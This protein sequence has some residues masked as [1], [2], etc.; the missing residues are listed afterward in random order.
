M[1]LSLATLLLLYGLPFALIV[2]W[3]VRS[4]AKRQAEHARQLEASLQAGL[5]E[6]ASLHPVVDPNNCLASGVCVRSCPEQALGIVN[7]KAVLVNAAACIGHGACASACPTD[8][9]RLVFGTEKRGID[10]PEVKPN[11]ESNVPG[12]YI[13]GELG[14]MGLVRKAA[15]QGRQAIESI[16]SAGRRG[17]DYDVVIVGAGPAGIAAGLGAIAHKLKYAI[18]EQERSLGGTVYHYPRNK[19]TMTAP[20]KLPVVG[21]VKLG[22]EISK[23]ALLAKFDEIAR[24]AGLK[25]RFGE[26]MESIEREGASFVVQT[27]RAS[28]RTGAVLLAIGR[29][30]TPR[31]LG[32]PGEE[33]PKVVYRL[34]DPEQYRDQKVLVVGGGDA[35]LEAAIALAD[36]PGCEV[37]L[38]YRSEA[39]SRVKPANRARLQERQDKR[40][41]RVLLKSTVRSISPADVTLVHDDREV[42]L[43]NDAVIV[44]A[45][46]ELPFDLL[47]KVGIAFETKR[48]TA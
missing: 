41:I 20:V 13:A 40:R 8:A 45:G 42:R 15:E 25:I 30:G 4:R 9:I 18:V 37:T 46:G 35:A 29:R 19:I 31:K 2:A 1:K 17:A 6:P 12:I 44:C 39:F 7:G 34:I 32:V 36:E 33:L 38:S 21:R 16:R 28:Y 5:N 3:Y 43:K 22:P 48:G 27:T 11:F 14:G 24:R 47:K 10:I 26:K 23:E